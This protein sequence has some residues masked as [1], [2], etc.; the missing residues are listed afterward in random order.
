[1]K[2]NTFEQ[3]KLMMMDEPFIHM[4]G[5]DDAIIG[6]DSESRMIYS[7]KKLV[8][9][10]ITENPLMEID[11][12]LDHISFNMINNSFHPDL[13]K[14]IFMMDWNIDS[15][16]LDQNTINELHDEMDELLDFGDSHEKQFGRGMQHV[17]KHLQLKT[18]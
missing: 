8:E 3:I 14:P 4:I 18:K 16:E 12:A 5:F 13:P 6:F 11:D 7:V 10:M 1:M 9:I 15:S 17:F 2:T